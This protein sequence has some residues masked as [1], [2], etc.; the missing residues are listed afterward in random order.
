MNNCTFIKSYVGSMEENFKRLKKIEEGRKYG[1]MDTE[2]LAYC[3]G[4]IIACE[5]IIDLLKDLNSHE[6]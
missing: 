4:G 5:K 1:K 6:I 2:F 3:R